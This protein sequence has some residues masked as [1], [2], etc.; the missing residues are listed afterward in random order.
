MRHHA[1]ATELSRP[2]VDH[3]IQLCF[4]SHCRQRHPL[5][6]IFPVLPE[7]TENTFLRQCTFSLYAQCLACAN[8]SPSRRPHVNAG[9]DA[10]VNGGRSGSTEP[11]VCAGE[12]MILTFS[13]EPSPRACR[14]STRTRSAGVAKAKNW[15]TAA[16]EAM[17]V[18][19]AAAADGPVGCTCSSCTSRLA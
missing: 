3:V 10:A 9:S 6:N 17:P 15:E 16:V 12:E 8:S 19:V 4:S 13:L 14:R 18:A 5:T 11:G 1:L 2:S 7:G